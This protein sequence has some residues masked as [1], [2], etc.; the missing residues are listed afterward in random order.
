[1]ATRADIDTCNSIYLWSITEPEDNALRLE[2]AEGYDA[3]AARLFEV[4]W[5]TYLS[6]QVTNESFSHPDS[7]E[8]FDGRLFVRYSVSRYLDFIRATPTVLFSHAEE[9]H[10]WNAVSHWALYC[11]N[12]SIDVI[13]ND[14]PM[15]RLLEPP[16]ES[17]A[18]KR[19]RFEATLVKNREESIAATERQRQRKT[20]GSG[21]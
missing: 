21:H 11:L 10:H 17:R 19:A 7:Y 15:I 14:E 9:I 3:D 4:V 8:K 16:W 6:Y 12:H 18:V 2:I 5:P 1:M 13:S 20:D